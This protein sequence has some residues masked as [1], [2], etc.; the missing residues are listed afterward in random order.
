MCVSD[1]HKEL[2]M[3]EW[4]KDMESNFDIEQLLN[5]VIEP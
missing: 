1:H 5:T 4:I 2:E 3:V